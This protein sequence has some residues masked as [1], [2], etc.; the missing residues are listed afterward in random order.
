LAGGA[1]VTREKPNKTLG[2]EGDL[3][4]LSQKKE[5]I[6]DELEVARSSFHA[7]LDSL[8]EQG[9]Y[10]RSQN[11]AWTNGQLLFHIMLGFILV[12]P[13]SRIMWVF[14]RFPR[15]CS[16]AFAALLNLGTP[17]FRRVNA[18]GPRIGSRIYD[19]DRIG[20]MYDRVYARVV[21]RLNSLG[22]EELAQGMFYPTRWD[23]GFAEYM[24]LEDLF[25]YPTK[26][27]KHHA[28]QIR[29]V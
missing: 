29:A 18:T 22:D 15:E 2:P 17:L 7:L 6:R 12:C 28:W 27:L 14:G 25:V 21:T 11:P 24:K 4:N 8:S 13:L 9:W 5:Y 16:K 19:R 1:G 10:E 26:H 23:P 3:K 20:L